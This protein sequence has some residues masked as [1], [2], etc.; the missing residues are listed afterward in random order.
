MEELYVDDG[1]FE[2]YYTKVTE[3]HNALENKLGAIVSEIK[4][5]SAAV[6]E[7]DFHTN[8]VSFHDKL[9]ETQGDLSELT[10]YMIEKSVAYLWQMQ[11]FDNSNMSI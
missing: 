4:K 1:D 7:G 8:L 11:E 5:A 9:V 2:L 3:V 10:Y 6:A